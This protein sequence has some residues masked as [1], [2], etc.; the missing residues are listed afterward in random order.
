MR[1]PLNRLILIFLLFSSFCLFAGETSEITSSEIIDHIRYL[2]SDRLKGRA[3]GTQGSKRAMHY[4]KKEWRKVGVVPAGERG[5]QQPFSFTSGVSLSGYNRFKID[6]QRTSF[7]VKHDFMPLGFSADG[8]FNANVVFAGYGFGVEDSVSWNDYSDIDATDK[9]VLIFRG[10]PDGNS[11]HSAFADYAPLRKKYLSARDNNAA[12]VLFVNPYH[13]D[14]LE[15]FIPL[16]FGP[17]SSKGIIPAI[18]I[19]QEIAQ[20]LLPQNTLL[21]ELQDQLDNDRSSLSFDLGVNVTATVSLKIKKSKGINLLGLIP[22]DGSTNEIIIIGAHLDHLGFGGKGSGSL[23]PDEKAIH[24]G[25]DDNASGAAGLLEIAEKLSTNSKPLKRDVLFIAFDAEE[26]GLLGSKY[27]VDNPTVNLENVSAMLNMDM[28]GRLKDSSLTVGGTGTSPLFEPLL[29]SLQ[30]NRPL[31]ISYS[32]EGYGPSDHS[33]F[34]IKDIPV[35]FFF[36]GSH[37]DYHKPTD[38]W[39]KINAVG[40]QKILELI[41]DITNHIGSLADKPVFTTAGPKEQTQ[42]RRGFKV[43]FGIIP[44]YAGGGPGL[45]IDGVRPEGPA[46]AAGIMGGD[47]IIEIGGKDVQDIYDYMHRLGELKKGQTVEVKVKRGEETLSFTVN[48]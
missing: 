20:Q 47:I 28:I 1:N 40:E 48:L 15:D 25:A 46:E 27:F 38:D 29:D 39:E 6:G 42:S 23:R 21:K 11:P 13:D 8:S 5:F 33:S 26:K 30:Q 9:W 32:K 44:S 16:R 17:S 18:H 36:T 35:L 45:T 12:G 24:N 34:Y 3:P 31:K 14:D 7:R 37:E 22:G 4:I 19:S 43:T 2:S 10:S 41:F